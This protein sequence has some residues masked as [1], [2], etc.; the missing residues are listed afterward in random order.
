MNKK[1]LTDVDGVLLDYTSSFEEWIENEKYPAFVFEDS[2]HDFICI[3]EWLDI[4]LAEALELINEFNESSYFSNIPAF[5]D[6]EKYVNKLKEDGYD[7]VAITACSSDEN[8]LLARKRNLEK[9][10]PGVFSEIIHTG[11][12][13]KQGKKPYLEQFEDCIW[14]EDT[15]KYALSGHEV[16]HKVY[17]MAGNRNL[18]VVP[19]FGI[20]GVNSWEQIYFDLTD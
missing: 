12:H 9:Y 17:L 16:G 15:Y 8:S 20:T 2:L 18:G 5:E 6:A 7:F 19:E 10:F 4:S 3:E 13:S 14:V 1:I 11:L